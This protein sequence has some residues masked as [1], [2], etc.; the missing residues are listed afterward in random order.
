MRVVSSNGTGGGA[1]HH[2]SASQRLLAISVVTW[3]DAMRVTRACLHTA[4][5]VIHG[6]CRL[7]AATSPHADKV[8]IAIPKACS[9]HSL[10]TSAHKKGVPQSAT[11]QLCGWLVARGTLAATSDISP[12]AQPCCHDVSAT[13]KEDASSP[14][15]RAPLISSC[16]QSGAAEHES[17]VATA[18]GSASAVITCSVWQRMLA[19][20]C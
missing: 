7:Q 11:A 4:V 8:H 5:S 1:S 17:S 10:A 15:D 2:A 19:E 20:K 6:K 12:H 13:F 14:P 16:E 9:R 3:V 18:T